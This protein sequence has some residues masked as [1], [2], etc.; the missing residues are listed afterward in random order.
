MLTVNGHHWSN[1]RVGW[2][3]VQ[4]GMARQGVG[5]CHG[6]S[7]APGMGN[8]ECALVQITGGR[9]EHVGLL[10]RGLYPYRARCDSD[11]RAWV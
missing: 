3:Q 4:V 5:H 10:V 7:Q 1:V 9:S 11:R 6:H 2:Q 8:V